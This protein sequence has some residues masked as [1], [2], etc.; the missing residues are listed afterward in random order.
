MADRSLDRSFGLVNIKKGR[1]V[2]RV[3]TTFQTIFSR[4]SLWCNIAAVLL[5]YI[6]F[7]SPITFLSLL[8]YGCLRQFN[9]QTETHFDTNVRRSTPILL[10]TTGTDSKHQAASSLQ[11]PYLA[12]GELILLLAAVHFSPLWR[13]G[14]SC[15]WS[16]CL[17][18]VRQ[19]QEIRKLLQTTETTETTTKNLKSGLVL[20]IQWIAIVCYL[21]V[22]RLLLV[23]S[24]FCRWQAAIRCLLESL[25]ISRFLMPHLP[26]DEV[27]E[28][29]IKHTLSGMGQ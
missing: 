19:R 6:N 7:P 1:C 10:A 27:T 29:A 23:A 5:M 28:I 9:S 22:G 16:R 14:R 24:R 11:P 21:S 18:F 15:H 4:S 3:R 20:A 25:V 12:R 2:Y 8:S 13:H 17:W 26:V